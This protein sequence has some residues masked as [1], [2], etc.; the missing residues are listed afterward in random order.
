MSEEILKALTQLFAIITKQDGG[1]TDVE[2]KFVDDFF[3]ARLAAETVAEYIALYN[4]F[5]V[6]KRK[7]RLDKEGN[8]RKA[9]V[10]TMTSM[11][12]SVRTLA[13]CKKINKTLAQKQKVIVVIQLLEL[14]NS[15]KNFSDQRREIINTVS[16]VFNIQNKE[17]EI[18]EQFVLEESEFSS[19]S[20]TNI[21][22]SSAKNPFKNEGIFLPAEDLDGSIVFLKIPSVDLYFVK[23]IGQDD[24]V[25]NSLTI[26]NYQVHLYSNGSSLK[27]SKSS[28]YYYSD[29][30]SHFNQS[31]DILPLTF[32]AEDLVFTF[33]NG[34]LG[35]RGINI[36]EKNGKLIGIMGA[37]G[38]G[39][40]TL[41]NVLAGIETPSSGTVKING[42]DIFQ[43]KEKIKGVIGYI[44]QDDILIEDLTVFENLYYNARLCFKTSSEDE[45]ITRVENTL[46]NLGLLHIKHLKVGNV[47][48]KKIS[49][50]QRKRLNIAL[51]LIREPAV[52]FVDEPTSGLSSRDSENVIDLLKE[53]SL[54]GKI[55]FV[56]IHQ[57]S[58]DIYKKFDK[59]FLMDTGGY[60]I[61]NGPPVEAVT[62]FKTASNQINS[63]KGQCSECGNVNPEQIFDI[64]EAKVVNEYGKLTDTRKVTPQEWRKA[65]DKS[66]SFI[67][68]EDVQEEPPNSLSI[69]S[70]LKQTII[71]TTRDLKSKFSNTQYLIINLL[72]APLLAALLAFIIRYKDSEAE[73]YVFMD[74]ENIP[75]YILMSIVVALFMG[76]TVSAEEIIKDQKILR[77][78]Q[79]LNLSRFSYLMSKVGILFTLSA[80]QTFTYVL[81]A[82]LILD[83]DG[84]LL[85]YWLV[86]FSISCFANLLGLNISASFSSAIT[87]YI[88]IPLLLIPQMIL[89]GAMFSF[90]NL[91][92][93]I[94]NKNK[95]PIISDMMASRWAYEAVTV[96]QF[97]AN[98]YEA[99]LFTYNQRK[100]EINFVKS[101]TIPKIKNILQKEFDKKEGTYKTVILNE[102]AKLKMN[103]PTILSNNYTFDVLEKP[104]FDL[105]NRDLKEL[106]KALTKKYN[107]INELIDKKTL[108]INQTAKKNGSSL[109][110]IKKESS[111]EQ[112]QDLVKNVGTKHRIILYQH[113][114]VQKYDPIYKFPQPKHSLD[115]RA[116]L[117]SPKKHFMGS[118][119]DT[120]NFN[121]IVIWM[122]SLFLFISLYFDFLKRIIVKTP[123]L[124]KSTKK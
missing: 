9:R 2:R 43:E 61:F 106:E 16:E 34:A 23:Y 59:M 98:N 79:F 54:K 40:T 85:T 52:M 117:Y 7:K 41:L 15:D 115:Y 73:S 113:E 47:L 105:I 94:T 74:N 50:G 123:N 28:P 20:S 25:L 99:P 56:V 92:S 71:Y 65:Y 109:L 51:E 4:E 121:I 66:S 38:A 95:T 18:I 22:I 19:F 103:Y 100:S 55:I 5:L 24:V 112:L 11:K 102:L 83:I 104:K 62:Y 57:P 26:R 17:Y 110:T 42:V 58:S 90:D 116:H 3:K 80:L 29:I 96:N 32:N 53:L 78:E 93:V 60:P 122:M 119:Y 97:K 108:A 76:L 21:I 31:E 77:R 64:V 70:R 91:N 89:S 37:S 107:K 63:D 69:P 82:N 27:P 6:D 45:I 114:L 10:S 111:N 13:I 36:S 48:N 14:I 118:Y 33:P 49:G 12:D 124:F 81:V 44:S 68:E 88:L 30:V 46:T 86:L 75:A 120:F 87:V 8:E 35:L 101:Y 67:K 84:M 39:K 1:P 72:E